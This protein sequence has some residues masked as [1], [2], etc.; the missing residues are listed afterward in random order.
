MLELEVLSC[1][2]LLLILSIMLV[3]LLRLKLLLHNEIMNL[4]CLL[5]FLIDSLLFELF[6]HLF[7]LNKIWPSEFWLVFKTN[8]IVAELESFLGNKRSSIENK[9]SILGIVNWA[10]FYIAI[11]VY[12][13]SFLL[14]L[15][16]FKAV[17][18]DS[19]YSILAKQIS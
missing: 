5:N 15:L 11:L 7:L 4:F 19:F 8:H 9:L 14:Y 18:K 13:F 6:L 17:Q 12:S 16:A 10:E 3:S 2:L 1:L